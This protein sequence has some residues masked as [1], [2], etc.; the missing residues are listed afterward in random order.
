LDRQFALESLGYLKSWDN[1][2]GIFAEMV[3]RAYRDYFSQH[4]DIHIQDLSRANEILSASK[5]PYYRI[6]EDNEI[7]G[8]LCRTMK[9]ESI[10]RTRVTKEGPQYRFEVEWLHSPK[11]EVMATE[12]FEVREPA[13][14]E[15]MRPEEMKA[16]LE[17]A[18]ALLFKKVPFL[19]QVNGRDAEMITLSIG[20]SSGL[21][22]R[23]VLTIGTL[24]EVKKH[25]LLNKIVDWKLSKVGQAIVEE[26]DEQMAFA[27]VS[28]EEEGRSLGKYQKI[29]LITPGS[30]PTDKKGGIG[31]NSS[32]GSWVPEGDVPSV[33]KQ[34]V[35]KN[36]PRYGWASIT[37]FLGE[38]ARD[39]TSSNGTAGFRGS[40]FLIGARVDGNLWFTKN[41]FA[42]VMVGFGSSSYTPKDVATGTLSG[43][44]SSMF[45]FHFRLAG[46]YTFLLT[47]DVLGPRG[48]VKLGFK[49]YSY[50]MTVSTTDLT[51]TTDF[52]T[53]M[54]GLG[55]DLPIKRGFGVNMDF[56]IGV[57]HIVNHATDLNAGNP[58]G[59]SG[60]SFYLGGY[61][62]LIP[63]LQVRAGAD[64]VLHAT[65]FSGGSSF[66]A[67]MISFSPSVLYYF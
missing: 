55:G 24:D 38:F 23:D 21:R 39:Y 58:S 66:A 54:I 20:R 6:I 30:D 8:R 44:S 45:N 49:R 14:G 46:G 62:T 7:L 64:F 25:P 65:S 4:A 31:N 28:Q 29:M 12:S 50:G 18:L 15:K 67:R 3:D 22:R 34:A 36:K 35:D 51:G 60:I 1:V 16:G 41:I 43:T 40:G 26:V 52:N 37:P 59:P 32:S 10:L 19:G 48:W 17:K 27:R 56:N 53:I 57:I 42:D 13:M 9:V 2:D 47:P 63:K 11:M 61:Y 33:Q 5:L